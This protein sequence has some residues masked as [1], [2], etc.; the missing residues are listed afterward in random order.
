MVYDTVQ[1]E[2]VSR[3]CTYPIEINDISSH[4][5]EGV[6][7]VLLRLG[8]EIAEGY[9]IDVIALGGAWHTLLICDE[10]MKPLTRTLSWQYMDAKNT[11]SVLRKNTDLVA[12]QYRNT[13]CMIHS[14]YPVYK[15]AHL[16]EC[17][18]NTNNIRVCGQSTYIFYRM[19][20]R[21][22]V[23]PCMASGSAFLNVYTKDYDP[24]SIKIA[25]IERNQLGELHESTETAPLNAESASVLGVRQ[26]IPVIQPCADGALNQIGSMAGPHD[27]TISVGTSAALRLDIVDFDI[28]NKKQSTWLYLSPYSWMLGAAT[29]GACNCVDWMIHGISENMYSY[30]KLENGYKA[31]TEPPFFMPFIFGERCPGW[32]DEKRG[33]FFDISPHHTVFDMYHSV[34]EGV[35][36]NI[37][38]CYCEICEVAGKPSQIL[39]SGGILKSRV[40]TQMAADIFERPLT[41]DPTD[42]SSLLGA[43]YLAEKIIT[44]KHY[45]SAA[46]KNVIYPSENISYRDRYNQYL[47]YY[48]LI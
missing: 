17:G 40:W 14:I 5:A 6:F 30:D 28:N 10:T 37:Y 13:G 4:D 38:Q 9:A 7:N 35:I 27:M 47:K 3:T 48:E 26:G 16:R 22:W 8:H 41:C 45:I 42:Q 33:G 39:L 36:F 44:G 2:F 32:N 1:R 21:R 18:I 46:C 11:T 24:G 29:S 25:G 34:L 20:N 19:T 43:A 23:T 12:E 15:M 31:G